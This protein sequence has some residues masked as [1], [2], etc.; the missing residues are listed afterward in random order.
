MTIT[1][2]EFMASAP[3][4]LTSNTAWGARYAEEIRRIITNHAARAPRSNQ[5]HLGPSE[6][7]V[8]CDRQVAGKMAGFPTTNHVSDPWP[9]IVGTAVHAWLAD[10]FSEENV[11]TGVRRW[12]T[13]QKVTPHPD[14]PGT[15][16]LYDAKERC[17]GDWKILG[18]TTLAHVKAVG[19]PPRKYKV[20]LKLYG[21]G[22]RRMGLPVDRIALIALPRTKSTLDNMFVWDDPYTPADDVLIDE[23]FA[24]T[25]HRANYAELLRR[26]IIALNDVPI[27]PDDSECFFCPFYRPQS[28]R[29]GQSGCPGTINNRP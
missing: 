17:V 12:L 18:E 7:G 15:G 10:C 26:G 16:D 14:H 1:P 5:V 4:P 23:V 13:E 8:A 3:K 2:S 9:S 25:R 29:D 27:T 11:R 6:I 21:L 20:Q 19:G 22:F 24:Q 28:A